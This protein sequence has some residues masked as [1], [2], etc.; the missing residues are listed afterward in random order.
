[1]NV[2]KRCALHEGHAGPCAAWPGLRDDAKP[3]D[4]IRCG[5]LVEPRTEIWQRVVTVQQM[6][7]ETRRRDIVVWTRLIAKA[8][9]YRGR[10]S[11]VKLDTV[12]PP[13]CD[14]YGIRVHPALGGVP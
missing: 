8:H 6:R 9:G 12:G 4:G 14:L 11:F 5:S 7:N 10:I 2:W 13:A 1:M 3:R